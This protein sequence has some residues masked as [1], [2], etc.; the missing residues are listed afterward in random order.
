MSFFETVL[1]QHMRWLDAGG[2]TFDY[3]PRRERTAVIVEPRPH[4]MLR[5]VVANVMS[6]LGDAWNLHV[7]TAESNKEWLRTTLAPYKYTVNYLNL[8]NLTRDQYSALLMT[9]EFW[10]V[11]PTEH[12]L[13]FQTDVVVFR[14]WNPAFE[15][16][17]YIGANY[18][19]PDHVCPGGVG[20]IQG[21][22][23]YRKKSAM[24]ACLRAISAA[25]VV[26]Y[27]AARGL[28]ALPVP[29]VE[30]IYFTHACA[31]LE[32]S[33]PAPALRPFFA[34]EAVYYPT[35]FGF[36]GWNHPYFTDAECRE[37]LMGS[38]EMRKWAM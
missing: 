16:Y 19:H 37:L 9:P 17:D 32:K 30:D 35:P 22:L 12:L 31:M 28:P 1:T 8:D 33:L 38:P 21:G 14:P 10:E 7:F 26:Q 5:V 18:Y 15:L 29:M 23:S 4:P 2:F 27:R 11:L 13:I 24:V 36:H 3:D 20:G 25:D 6:F 34:I